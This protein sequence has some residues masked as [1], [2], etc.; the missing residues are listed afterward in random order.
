[1]AIITAH[2]WWEQPE[3]ADYKPWKFHPA[4]ITEDCADMHVMDIDGDG[5]AD[6]ISTS[7]HKYGF[8]WSQQKDGN[9]FIQ[10]PLF[11]PPSEIAKLP[12]DL[13]LSAEEQVLHEAIKKGRSDLFTAPLALD[14]QLCNLA[15]RFAM[16]RALGLKVDFGEDEIR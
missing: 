10:R 12:A 3:K 7:A 6:I 9:T 15:R 11:L 2:G 14:P 4:K 5:K 8:W 13:K 1:I 16:V